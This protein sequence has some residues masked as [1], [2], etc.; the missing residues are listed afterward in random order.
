MSAV[1]LSLRAHRIARFLQRDGWRFV[2]ARAFAAELEQMGTGSMVAML[3]DHGM[4]M[5]Q[6]YAWLTRVGLVPSSACAGC[7]RQLHAHMKLL[8]QRGRAYCAEP[9]A[10]AAEVA[11]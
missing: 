6:A 3:I 10:L 4:S 11:S 5:P 7:G 1:V 8:V 2:D 9:C